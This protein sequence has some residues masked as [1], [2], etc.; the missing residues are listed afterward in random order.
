MSIVYKPQIAGL[1]A[2][3]LVTIG[4]PANGLSI[5]SSQELTIA[6]S[7][8]ST[9]GALSDT[10]WN[11][12]NNKQAAGNYITALTGDATASGPGSVALTLATVN[13]DVGTFGSS[14]SIPTFTVNAKGLITAASG[15][16]VIA[17]AGTLTGTTLAAN[18]VTSSLTTVGT[19][20]SGTWNGTTIAIANGGTGQTTQTAA[21]DA[22]SPTTTKGDL[23]VDDGTNVIRKAAG[24]NGTYVKYDSTAAGGI[25]ADAPGGTLAYRSVTTTDSPSNSDNVL[26]CSGASFTITLYTAVGN[27]G[28][29]LDIIHNGTSLTQAYTLATTSGQTIGGIASGSYVLH[30]NGE[31]LRLISDGSNWQIIGH[32]TD[33][34]WVSFT[35]TSVTWLAN[36]TL[37][38]F[39][40]RQGDSIEIEVNIA[41]SGTPT[42]ATMTFNTLPGSLTIDTAKVASPLSGPF[43][44]TAN[45]SYVDANG[46]DIPGWATLDNSSGLMQC[47]YFAVSGALT[48][49]AAVTQ[50]APFTW[51]SGD[52]ANFKNIVLPI[53]GWQP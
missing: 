49:Y 30:T 28:R 3:S 29:T 34:P 11:T 38:G 1:D 32:N 36:V 40:R 22:L 4:S 15:N 25:T 6:L 19:I 21:M 33:T 42:T 18:V 17:P 23:L 52:N 20:T 43:Q 16:A 10:D 35:P 46:V 24:T 12:F 2:V 13:A 48:Q 47:R 31:R 50:A 39:W 9:T 37:T 27:T 8:T 14:T 45:A 41:V 26:V 51:A 44:A 5:N 7:S 53:S